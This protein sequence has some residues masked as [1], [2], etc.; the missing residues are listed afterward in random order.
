VAAQL[1]IPRPRLASPRS[2]RLRALATL[3]SLRPIPITASTHGG[4]PASPRRVVP[5]QRLHSGAA[6]ST[7][8]GLA[9]RGATLLHPSCGPAPP[10]RRRPAA[11]APLCPG[12]IA[13]RWQPCF[14]RLTARRSSLTSPPRDG[15]RAP[16]CT[17]SPAWPPAAPRGLVGAA[18]DAPGLAKA[19][20][21][22]SI[23]GGGP[24]GCGSSA[25]PC[26]ARWTRLAGRERR[27]RQSCAA[28]PARPH[29]SPLRRVP[30]LPTQPRPALCLLCRRRRADEPPPDRCSTP[31]GWAAAPAPSPPRHGLVGV[32]SPPHGCTTPLRRATRWPSPA[33]CPPR[34]DARV[35]RLVGARHV[36][37]ILCY[38]VSLR[39]AATPL[40]SCLS[41]T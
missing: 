26:P 19:R 9:P 5:S 11:A 18:A 20:R 13:L 30:P 12:N 39:I 32:P 4:W 7:Q 27:Q 14:T 41:P 16:P 23:G 37:R 21:P 33:W 38:R 34:L 29:A 31:P 3:P 2:P 17:P 10:W 24:G 28:S 40:S 36:S 35:L 22:A 15:G 25:R 1:L 8:H 6:A